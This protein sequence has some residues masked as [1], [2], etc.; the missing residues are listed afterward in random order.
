MNASDERVN[1]IFTEAKLQGA[2][3]A[4]ELTFAEFAHAIDKGR[5]EGLENE[6]TEMVDLADERVFQGQSA[7]MVYVFLV[8]SFMVLVGT[9]SQIFAYFQCQTFAEVEPQESYLYRDY[10]VDCNGAR[11]LEHRPFVLL[12]L[13]VYPIGS[14]MP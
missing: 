5:L 13:L 12:M 7:S 3:D 14:A 6:F 10:S 4:N 1:A 8:F 9:S 11:Y 2:S